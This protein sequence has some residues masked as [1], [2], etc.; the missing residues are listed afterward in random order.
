M[1]KGKKV[2]VI[3][4]AFNEEL[5]IRRAIE[6]FFTHGAVDEIVAVDNNST[7]NTAAEIRKTRAVYVRETVQGY[8]AALIRGLREATGDILIM[9]EPEGTFIAHDLD[10]LLVYSE[11]YEVI[12][13]TRTSKAFIWSGAV[14]PWSIRMGNWAVAKFLEYLWNGPSLTDV[15]CTYK[16]IHRAA[17]ERLKDCLTVSGNHFSVDFMIAAIRARTRCVEIPV[18]YGKRVGES[19]ITGNFR[20]AVRLGW[21]MI[22]F[23]LGGR[24]SSFFAGR[25]FLAASLLPATAVYYLILHPL[26][27]YFNA[28]A[29]RELPDAF[30]FTKLMY[31]PEPLELPVYFFGFLFIPF[32]A[33]GLNW[34]FSNL[35]QR[36][37]KISVLLN[38][39]PVI[40]AVVILAVVGYKVTLHLF[41]FDYWKSLEQRGDLK[42]QAII[43]LS[44]LVFLFAYF[45]LIPRVSFSLIN[46]WQMKWRDKTKII[47]WLTMGAI[48]LIAVFLFNP[49]FTFDHFHYDYFLHSINDLRH[50]KSLLYDT[51]NQYGHL[52][53]YFLYGL[54]FLLGKPG[55]Q[56]LALVFFA[57]IAAWFFDWFRFLRYFLRSEVLA[58]AAV[59]ASVALY[60]V[61]VANLNLIY[62]APASGVYRQVVFL[63]LL[64]LWARYLTRQPAGGE[65]RG[66]FLILLVTALGFFWFVDSGIFLALTTLAAFWY[67]K[68][69]KVFGYIAKLGILILSLGG[70]YSL[71]GFIAHKGWPDWSL[72]YE[73]AGL[74]QK[75]FLAYPLPSHGMYYFFIAV[76]L[77]TLLFILLKRQDRPKPEHIL[78][79]ILAVYGILQLTYYITR[80]YTE[81]LAPRSGFLLIAL[82]CWWI[83]M[84]KDTQY[85]RVILAFSAS[86]VVFLGFFGGYAAL[87]TLSE[88]NYLSLGQN[89]LKE[90]FFDERVFGGS[91]KKVVE[92]IEVLRR[93]Y[94]FLD[95]PAILHWDDVKILLDLGKT[96]FFTPYDI[97]LIYYRSQIDEFVKEIYEKK[98]KYLFLA[99]TETMEFA[100]FS[101]YADKYEYFYEKIFPLYV[102]KEQLNT[103]NIYSLKQ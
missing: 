76:Y 72:A 85:R 36:V 79:L 49:N 34:F 87:R 22:F 93:D 37:K 8:G 98:P 3:F 66:E 13:G 48:V 57:V 68:G 26:W 16:L 95:G 102:Q 45:R 20:R 100:P 86:A 74:F 91:Q 54:S 7:D 25:R 47:R 30:F 43:L 44:G 17:Y 27:Q 19:K 78:P 39:W 15:G 21:R 103:I 52:Q 33:L 63:I 46:S 83:V 71:I 70:A 29:A 64:M 82:V 32:L 42:V 11:D 28:R 80:S 2:S 67:L 81:N 50:G 58:I 31:R 1:Y 101:G 9:C 89:F 84:L 65:T 59:A 88:R 24:L 60:T 92:D 18:H 96:N 35:A 14:M 4:P 90:R 75:G 94:G 12:F 55:Y 69:L 38:H 97:D 56:A 77:G 61:P 99:R 23:I 5:N 6:E 73:T 40:T 10:K 53:T 41:W 62:D 51:A